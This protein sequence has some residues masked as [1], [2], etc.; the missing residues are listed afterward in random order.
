MISSD[1]SQRAEGGNRS[2]GDTGY[3]ARIRWTTHGVPHITGKSI[4]DVIFGQ[5]WA[6]ARDHFAT[7]ADQVLKVR[8]E[9]SA[10][11]GPGDDDAHLNSDFGYRSL[12]LYE[13]AKGMPD[14]QPDEIVRMVDAYSAGLNAWLAEHGSG[15]VAEWCAGAPWIRPISTIDLL[16]VYMDLAIIA[17]GR[18]LAGYIG[19]AQPPGRSGPSGSDDEQLPTTGGLGSNGWALGRDATTTGRGIVVANPHFPWYG[20]ARFWECHLKAEGDAEVYGVCLLGTPGVQIG[21]NRTVA[22]THT[23]SRGHRFTVYKLELSGGDPTSY[24]FGDEVREMTSENYTISVKGEDGGLNEVSRTLWKSQYGPMLALPILGW[25]DTF[26]FTFRDANQN[27][28]RFLPL[29]LSMD[30]AHGISGLKTAFMDHQ[31]MPWVNTMAADSEGR[32]WYVDSSPTPAL[33]EEAEAAFV[34]SVDTDP[35]SA[36]MFENRV[37]MLD[38]SDPRFEWEEHDGAAEPGLLPFEKLPQQERTDHVFNSN[39]PYWLHHA[40]DQLPRHAALHGLHHRPVT[41]RT[42]MNATLLGGAGPVGPSG[43]DGKFSPEDLEAAVL[44]NHS[45]LAEQLLDAVVERCASAGTAQ[46][47]GKDVD[48]SDA[49]EVLRKWDRRFDLD[50]V[51]AVLWREFLASFN[52]AALKDIGPLFAERWDPADPVATPRGLAPAAPGGDDPIPAALATAIQV[53]EAAEIPIDSPL[54]DVQFVERSGQRIPLHGANEVEGIANVLAPVGALEKH[55]LEPTPE[56]LPAI[57]GRSER[58][59][60]RVGGYRATYGASFLMVAWWDEDGPHGRGLLAYGQSGDPRSP[61]H[62]DQTW[63]YSRKELRPFLLD[64]EEIDADPNLVE[65]VVRG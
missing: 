55:D 40:V 30:R 64:D 33:S 31:G 41:P 20:E 45:L 3:E 10:F 6:C 61:H 14:T 25:S 7:I 13:R 29:V 32:C 50:S 39:D 42:R 36:L 59:G 23:F 60:I 24:R 51:G 57:A 26:G 37:A 54:G 49:V 46:V 44:G 35:I 27:N 18:N 63:A 2:V 65:R 62:A 34:E 28:D 1:G 16:A 9:R 48:L 11:F 12:G 52:D 5:A 53:L 19:A 22:W 17:S 43:P 21:M 8:A 15:A 4:E 38:G 56:E 47:S 58:T